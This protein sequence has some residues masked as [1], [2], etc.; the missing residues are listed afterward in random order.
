MIRKNILT[1]QK[2][3]RTFPHIIF[4][5]MNYSNF[6]CKIILHSEN[7]F[8]IFDDCNFHT[9]IYVRL[10]RINMFHKYININNKNLIRHDCDMTQQ[11][12]NRN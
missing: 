11:I 10:Y 8:F 3:L 1:F 6:H 9:V 5:T 7:D 12:R 2:Y 4:I